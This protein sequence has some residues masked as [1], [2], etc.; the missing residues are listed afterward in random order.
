MWVSG[1]GLFLVILRLTWFK[2]SNKEVLCKT[3]IYVI[4]GI[5]NGYLMVIWIG[6]LILKLM[7]L[8]YLY[9]GFL[10]AA[11]LSAVIILKD[12]YMAKTE[13]ISDS[14]IKPVD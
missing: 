2:K 3:F 10:L 8:E 14:V 4:A 11:I 12:F 6:L 5:F 1:V 7:D 9:V 13:K